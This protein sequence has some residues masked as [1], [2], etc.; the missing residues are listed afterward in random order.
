LAV[1]TD[2]ELLNLTRQPQQVG[3][4][5][6]RLIVAAP[7]P[8]EAPDG[9]WLAYDPLAVEANARSMFG[10]SVEWLPASKSI[11]DDLRRFGAQNVLDRAH[12]LAG[13]EVVE[14]SYRG[15]RGGDSLVVGTCGLDP[16]RRDRPNVKALEARLPTSDGYDVRILDARLCTRQKEHPRSLAPS[17]VAVDG[18]A[19]DAGFQHQLDV[20]AT[21]PTRTWGPFVPW[22]VVTALAGGAVIL[23]DPAMTPLLREAAIY[24]AD[25]EAETVL[26]ALTAEPGRLDEQRARG[27]AFCRDRASRRAVIDLIGTLLSGRE[28][29]P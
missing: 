12:L 3:I 16:R 19:D 9:G 1:V 4:R 25:G 13:P 17:W 26:R 14:R 24:A 7:H 23:A 6:D 27:Y 8:P 28:D 10:T 21:I 18:S 29:T 5:P 15:A 2:P 20:F 22:T 11:A